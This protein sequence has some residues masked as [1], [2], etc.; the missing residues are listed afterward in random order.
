M[1]LYYGT[2]RLH[3]LLSPKSLSLPL[4]LCTL[5]VG[6]DTLASSCSVLIITILEFAGVEKV[7]LLIYIFI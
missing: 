5:Q 7:A 4:G 2:V 3:C 6:L 1:Y